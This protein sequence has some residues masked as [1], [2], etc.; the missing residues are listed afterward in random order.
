[1]Y[2]KKYS[3]YYYPEIIINSLDFQYFTDLED[4]HRTTDYIEYIV[5]GTHSLQN[6]GADFIIMAA[7]SPH[8]VF[9]QVKEQTDVP[10]ISIVETAAKKAIELKLKKVLLTGIKY[11]MEENFYQKGFGENDIEV[12]VPNEVHRN[13][14]NDII[15]NELVLNIITDKTREKFKYIISKYDVD[16]VILGCTELPLL[17]NQNDTDYKLLD[18]LDLHC[19]A[20]LEYTLM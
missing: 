3:N 19:R 14:I 16:G 10:M 11:T 9:E 18:T 2:Y 15:F 7:N 20:V 4:E 6:A 17:L 8:S 5:N 13:E 12:I 1:M